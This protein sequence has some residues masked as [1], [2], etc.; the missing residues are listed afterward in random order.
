MNRDAKALIPE[1]CQ[2]P[3]VVEREGDSAKLRA[4]LKMSKTDRCGPWDDMGISDEPE[5]HHIIPGRHSDVENLRKKLTSDPVCIDINDAINGV[6]LPKSNK[7][8]SNSAT[9]KRVYHNCTFKKSY[10]AFILD[11]FAKTKTQGE[12]WAGSE[13][14]RAC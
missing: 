7:S 5:A 4:N 11:S 12:F 13:K 9:P 10:I 8:S 3:R 2:C 14:I 6:Y 1:E